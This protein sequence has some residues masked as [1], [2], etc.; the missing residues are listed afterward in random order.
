MNVNQLEVLDWEGS[1]WL[2]ELIW[3][4]V[5]S[6]VISFECS[7]QLLDVWRC[8]TMNLVVCVVPNHNNQSIERNDWTESSH[9]S[10]QQSNNVN[11]TCR[12]LRQL[13]RFNE[14]ISCWWQCTWMIE[15]VTLKLGAKDSDLNKI[16]NMW[17]WSCTRADVS[18]INQ[19][20]HFLFV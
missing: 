18:P 19:R 9:R 3:S 2:N 15:R 4:N 11:E 6:Y 17:P 10:I 13:S 1:N 8:D 20:I 12:W 5:L 7:V 14:N 16:R